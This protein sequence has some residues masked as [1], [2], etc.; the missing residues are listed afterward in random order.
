[1]EVWFGDL[2][3]R[4]DQVPH[5]ELVDAVVPGEP[6]EVPELLGRDAQEIGQSAG[7]LVDVEPGP[8]ARVLGGD[9]DGAAPGIADTVLLAADGH[10]RGRADGHDVGAE[11]QGLDEVR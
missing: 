7:R 1:M 4:R 2:G 3:A 10:E 6:G 11:G 8:Q 9:A 5:R